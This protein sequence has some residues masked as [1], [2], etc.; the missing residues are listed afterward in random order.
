M[1]EQKEKIRVIIDK[2]YTEDDYEIYRITDTSGEPSDICG[3]GGFV[4]YEEHV[5]DVLDN[6]SA[7]WDIEIVEDYR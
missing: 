3:N 2:W 5:D 6:A 4:M 7:E 1:S